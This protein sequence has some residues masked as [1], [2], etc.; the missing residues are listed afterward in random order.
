MHCAR[1]PGS[2]LILKSV[3]VIYSYVE[4]GTVTVAY[5]HITHVVSP[6]NFAV[7]LV[8]KGEIALPFCYWD[9]Y[10]IYE[11]TIPIEI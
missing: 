11:A 7:D 9:S 8:Q 10:D 2:L 4:L 6:G 5:V 3:L 1:H